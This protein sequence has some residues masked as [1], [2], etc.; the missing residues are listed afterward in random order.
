VKQ[1]ADKLVYGD[2]PLDVHDITSAALRQ[3]P[4][5]AGIL[6][7]LVH[8]GWTPTQ[9]LWR[10][11]RAHCPVSTF[12]ALFRT[13]GDA[14][15]CAWL[16]PKTNESILHCIALQFGSSSELVRLLVDRGAPP[17]ARTTRGDTAL[18]YY[19]L[20]FETHPHLTSDKVLAG[21]H[22]WWP[23]CDS[24]DPHAVHPSIAALL[25]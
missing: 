12:H 21:Y 7:A 23:G 2:V 10:A 18:D 15:D 3:V 8:I 24:E 22:I 11:G 6:R 19:K 4:V 25:T 5:A 20:F 16:D 14:V 13:F 9:L 1:D 17:R